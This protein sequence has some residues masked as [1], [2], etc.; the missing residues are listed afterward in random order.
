M[1]FQT[2][3]WCAVFVLLMPN[4]N[5][6]VTNRYDERPSRTPPALLAL[7]R[8]TEHVCGL[9]AG[10]KRVLLGL[11]PARPARRRRQ[12][13]D[14]EARRGG[15]R[16]EADLRGDQRRSESHVCAYARGRGLLLGIEPDR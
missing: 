3:I 16:D 14:H 5:V 8:G 6:Q 9:A 1:S 13:H 11:E 15:G 2:T 10:W 12:Q 7:T 4:E